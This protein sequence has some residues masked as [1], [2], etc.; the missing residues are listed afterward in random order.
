MFRILARVK[1]VLHFQCSIICLTFVHSAVKTLLI[2]S[3]ITESYQKIF[4]IMSR[5]AAKSLLKSLGVLATMKRCSFTQGIR[6][7]A[8]DYWQACI[9]G[10]MYLSYE[11]KE[12]KFVKSRVETTPW[13]LSLTNIYLF[14]DS[15][16]VCAQH[17]IT[18][19][20][21]LDYLVRS[22]C[23]WVTWT[24]SMNGNGY[25]YRLTD[26]GYNARHVC[27]SFSLQ[28]SLSISTNSPPYPSFQRF[29]RGPRIRRSS[30]YHFGRMSSRST[31]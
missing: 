23:Y 7:S 27:F 8:M 25:Y 30:R 4:R 28:S 13:P 22:A 5:T 21:I 12:R 6:A 1:A 17:R 2:I 20:H 3:L 11:A 31:R 10:T 16:S 9:I 15:T 18:I 24:S 19:T 14:K 26:D 29:S